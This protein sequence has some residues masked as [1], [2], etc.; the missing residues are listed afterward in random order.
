MAEA[1]VSK[2]E[3]RAR[4]LELLDYVGLGAR[5]E[6][7]ATQLSGGE[8]QRVAIARALA[9]RP[10]ILL[11]D[12]PTG[13][14][15]AATGQE[16]LAL[17]RR[18]NADGTTLV[19]VTHDEHLAAE[20]SRVVR[21]LDGRGYADRRSPFRH[22]W[23][24][25]LRSMFLLL[26][27]ALG[28][29]VMIVL[30]SVGQA[31]L[32][33]SRDVVA[34]RRRRG[35]GAPAGDR[36]RGAPDRRRE[37]D[38]LRHRSRALRRP[39]RCI[40]GPRHRAVVTARRAGDRGEAALR[41][42]RGRGRVAV[43]AGGEIPSRS[44]ALGAGLD[45]LAGRW[46]DSPADSAYI[47]PT[48]QQLYDELDRFHR[49]RRPDSTW[50]EWHYFNV[51]TAPDEWWYITYLI[52][53]EVPTGRWRGGLLIT[54]RRADGRYERFMADVPSTDVAFDTSRAD[55]AIGDSFVRQRDGTYT[56]QARARGDAGP[57]PARSRRSAGRRIRYFPPV[58]VDDGDFQSGYV[59][60]ALA[61]S[62]SGTICVAG[63]CTRVTGASAYHDH[64]WGVWRDV[65]WEWGAARGTRLSLLYGG[66]YGP[67][68]ANSPFILSLVDSL[69]VRQVLRF[70][71][72]H[73]RGGRP[74][75]GARGVSAPERFSLHRLSRRRYG[76]TRRYGGRCPRHVAAAWG[77]RSYFL[78]MRGRF[79]IT[80]RVAATA[81]CGRG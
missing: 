25:K 80:G 38:V 10:A 16:I 61:A 5:A 9:N 51:V 44:R 14:L 3:R 40:G 2:R 39:G 81:A 33:Q 63:R 45:L 12:E 76:T 56:L 52:G 68:Q 74:A 20:A 26:G 60:P 28:V 27:F 77:R 11:A 55:L 65:T 64:N 22:L 57:V 72:V 7:R 75:A 73:Y 41:A 8:M 13:E 37:R 23:V 21:M 49:P 50:A 66:V 15:D 70:S 69:G 53:G 62:A 34:R 42:A 47:A 36:H 29:G 32:D 35:D 31:M 6:H 46:E 54:H 30:L 48:A 59:V 67:E 43:R 79:T 58:E 24:R 19:V 1:G 78:Q 4:A 18:L 71:R 17:F